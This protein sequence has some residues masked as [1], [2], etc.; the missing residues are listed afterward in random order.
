MNII[1]YT[2]FKIKNCSSFVLKTQDVSQANIGLDNAPGCISSCHLMMNAL[3]L[4]VRQII[5]PIQ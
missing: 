4:Q 1:V 5:H 3:A 2:L